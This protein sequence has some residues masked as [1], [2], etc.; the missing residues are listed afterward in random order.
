MALRFIIDVTKVAS[1]GPEHLQSRFVK[2]VLQYCLPTCASA[3]QV[4]PAFEI[5]RPKS[6]VHFLTA[7]RVADGRAASAF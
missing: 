7:A 1:N 4:V 2:D 6:I 3:S 5:F